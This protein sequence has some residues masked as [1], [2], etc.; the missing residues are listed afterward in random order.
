M[1]TPLGYYTT[2]PMLPPSIV[3][4]QASLK[5]KGLEMPKYIIA[6]YLLQ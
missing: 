4:W 3:Y 6:S 5:A 1:I 2:I